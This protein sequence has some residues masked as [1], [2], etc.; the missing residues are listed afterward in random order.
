MQAIRERIANLTM[1][2]SHNAEHMQMLR[3]QA[4]QFY[5]VRDATGH[6]P[7]PTPRPPATPVHVRLRPR[8]ARAAA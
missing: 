1:V 8:A 4:G 3:Y 5:K 2:P 7:Q 6:R